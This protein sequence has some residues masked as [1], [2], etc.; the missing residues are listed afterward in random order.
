[1][2]LEPGAPAA[3]YRRTVAWIRDDPDVLGAL[4]TTHKLDL[5]RA[6]R[7]PFDELD[8]LADLLAGVS[9]VAVRDGR[10]HG[11]AAPRTRSS[12]G[13]ARRL[14]ARRRRRR[15][16]DVLCMGSRRGGRRVRSWGCSRAGARP[17]SDPHR[18]A[19][20][21]ARARARAARPR[22]P[23]PA[24][25]VEYVLVD[26]GGTAPTGLLAGAAARARSSSTRR[27][28]GK[29][30]PG[31]PLE[32][33]RDTGRKDAVAWEQN[34]R[35]ELDFLAQARAAGR[36][37]R[38]RRYFIFGWTAVMELVFQRPIGAGDI[39]RLAEAAAFARRGD[40][41]SI[42]W[43]VHAYAWTW[44]TG[45][46]TTC[47]RSST[48]RATSASTRS[49]SRA[50]GPAR[51]GASGGDAR[52]R[53]EAPRVPGSSPRRCAARRPTRAAP[54][55]RSARRRATTCPRV[56]RTA[57]LGRD[58]VLGRRPLLAPHGGRLDGRPERVHLERSA[59]G[60]REGR[61]PRRRGAA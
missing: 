2:D 26:D 13:G 8:P 14:P 47:P 16:N 21:A 49:R 40:D 37:R 4:V 54:T 20:R 42:T 17:H 44:R 25:E 5:L 12:G 48:A 27:G 58:A 24:T 39:E 50:D 9:C 59:G 31:T 34:Y 19:R 51:R 46:T 56:R 53:H 43:A 36:A 7:D 28:L 29:D 6:A 61:R 15:V 18:H 11:W 22:S 23:H 55:P 35:G 60:L 3:A 45:P 32:R 52:A 1:M 10:L 57:G 38:G 33:R 41:M 30:R